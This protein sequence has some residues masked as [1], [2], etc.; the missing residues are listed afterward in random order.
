MCNKLEIP[1]IAY[2][3]DTNYC[4]TLINMVN[5][6]VLYY[7]EITKKKCFFGKLITHLIRYK[8]CHS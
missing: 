8:K 6:N 1:F 5:I 2:Y 7:I 3:I 4:R